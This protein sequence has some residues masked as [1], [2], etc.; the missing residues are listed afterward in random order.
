[1]NI[2]IKSECDSRVFVYPLLKV[3]YNFGTLCLYTSN[4]MIKRLID[5]EW[6][7][8]FNNIAINYVDGDLID[9]MEANDDYSGKYDYTIFDNV[10]QTDF[11]ICIAIVTGHIS[12]EY[13][14]NLMYIIDEPTTHIVKMGKAAPKIKEEK[15]KAPKRK[16]GEPLTEEEAVEE[17][18]AKDKKPKVEEEDFPADEPL[19]NKWVDTRTTEEVLTEKLLARDAKWYAFPTFDEIELM[20][21]RHVMIMPKDDLIKKVYSL[22]GVQTG[23]DEHNF[24]KGVKVSN[25]SSSIVGGADVR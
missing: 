23:V 24:V 18:T 16:K 20:E 5:N 9:A 8:G 21:N 2:C 12:D 11:D 19:P 7:G 22:I 3:L 17:M 10:G 6:Q 15:K 14:Q 4:P 25:E 1:M 13:I